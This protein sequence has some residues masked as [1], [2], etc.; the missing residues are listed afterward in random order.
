MNTKLSVYEII[1]KKDEAVSHTLSV[2]LDDEPG[3]LS[4]VIGVFT[5]RGYNIDS[6][7]VSSVDDERAVSRIT[8]VTKGS[9][10]VIEQIMA[11]LN[12]LVPVYSVKDLTYD[13]PHIERAL[14]LVKVL[15]DKPEDRT[16]AQALADRFGART[17]DST[18]ESFVFELADLP[19]KI[20]KF[21]TLM[22]PFGV[23]EVAKTGVT[24]LSK[25]K[26]VIEF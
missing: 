22:K 18:P 17:I 4:R 25:G 21:I 2:I 10:A 11:L 19:A 6:L 8:I 23:K 14:A 16:A 15:S 9:Y 13:S 5:S 12:R 24:A 20:E 7:T 26:E 1:E 3:A